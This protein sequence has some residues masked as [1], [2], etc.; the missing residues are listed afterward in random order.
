MVTAILTK[1]DFNSSTTEKVAYIFNL[2]IILLTVMH[3]LACVWLYLGKT[4]LDSWI[5]GGGE[6]GGGPV[7]DNADSYT[8]YVTAFYW[9][10]TT[11]TTVGYG[12]FRGYTTEEFCFQMFVEFLGIGVFSYLMNAINELFS[13]EITLS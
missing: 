7:V 11:L 9:V 13:S 6:K 5:D 3:I 10:A 4:V 12:D 1:Y 2:N 8:L